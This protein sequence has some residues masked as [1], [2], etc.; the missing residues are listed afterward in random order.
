MKIISIVN[1]KGGCGKTTT[2]INL[3]AC[4]AQMGYKILLIDL[5]PQSHA[6]LGLGLDIY[7]GMEQSMYEVM[8]G[9]LTA[10]NKITKKT[11]IPNLAIA[12]SN[13]TLSGAEIDLV[14]TIGRE[15]VLKE[16]IEESPASYDYIFIDCPPSLGLLT[17]NALTASDYMIIPVQTHYFPLEGMKQLFKTIDIVKKKLN[18][19]LTILGILITFYDKRTNM[20]KEI[21]EG[22]KSY[23]GNQVFNAIINVNVKLV[24]AQSASLAIS[25]YE[26]SSAGARDYGLLAEEVIGRLKTFEIASAPA[27]PRNDGMALPRND[28]VG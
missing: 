22:I 18:H 16:K 23:F 27:A 3:C 10:V 15:N 4:L 11:S 21:A 24:E 26:P 28:R 13:I 6:S 2:A 17:L 7:G 20:S 14:N 5:D 8:V 9:L 12:P 19:N 1:Q 25:L